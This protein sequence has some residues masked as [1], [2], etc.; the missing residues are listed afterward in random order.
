MPRVVGMAIRTRKNGPMREIEADEVVVDGGLVSD[1]PVSRNRGLT[2]LSSEQW[3]QVQRELDADLPWH[4]RRANVLVEGLPLADLLG[5]RVQLGAI[6]LEIVDETHPCEM[7]DRL[8]QGLRA[9]LEPERRGGV[10]GRVLRGGRLQLGDP[11][12]IVET[13]AAAPA[14]D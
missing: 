9:V 7:M 13:A 2:L 10:H 12:S 11:V 14:R 8:H 6:E 3:S 4:T 5:R 1:V